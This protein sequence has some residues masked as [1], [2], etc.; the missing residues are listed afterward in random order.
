MHDIECLLYFLQET[1]HLEDFPDYP[2]ALNGLQ[3]AG[4]EMVRR[5]G[6]A[7]DASEETIRDAVQRGVDLLVVHH[8]LFWDGLGPLTGPRYRKVAALIRGGV[9]LYSAHLPLDAHPDL[10]NGVLLAR[11]LGLAPEGPFGSFKGVHVGCRSTAE[12][13]RGDLL[14]RLEHAVSG[15]VRLIPGGPQ[16]ARRIGILT[17]SGASALK[18]AAECGLDTLVTG[19]APHHAYHQ[20]MELGINLLLGGHYAT[21]T[22]GVKAL[23]ELLGR[24]FSLPWEFLHHPT[25]F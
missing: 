5:V 16:E 14:E 11:S 19:E 22:F 10:G 20:A 21:E 8:G 25:G 12:M 17:G 6:G 24:Q 13:D 3:V 1:L 15:P 18:E 7:V 4:P 9:A 2:N 23:A